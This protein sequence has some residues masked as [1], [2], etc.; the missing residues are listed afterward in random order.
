M[1]ERAVPEYAT[2]QAVRERARSAASEAFADDG[3]ANLID[4][5]WRAVRAD[6]TH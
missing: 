2:W 6:L 5:E 4:G 3:P 1:P